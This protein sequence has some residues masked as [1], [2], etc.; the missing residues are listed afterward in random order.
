[1]QNIKYVNLIILQMLQ[2]IDEV[3]G[4]NPGTIQNGQN[5]KIHIEN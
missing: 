4:K 1:M 2:D 3:I 5:A